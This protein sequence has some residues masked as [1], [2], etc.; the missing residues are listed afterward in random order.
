MIPYILLI[1]TFVIILFGNVGGH[2]VIE[3]GVKI[4]KISIRMKKLLYWML[5]TVLTLFT[6]G[7]LAVLEF[8]E[9][10]GPSSSRSMP[11][12]TSHEIDGRKIG[13]T[14]VMVLFIYILNAYFENKAK[15]ENE[16]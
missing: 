16:K 4:G 7:M 15:K 6:A 9:P 10:F 5:Y 11:K 12:K 2:Y 1:L 13:I 8:F 14:I 3:K